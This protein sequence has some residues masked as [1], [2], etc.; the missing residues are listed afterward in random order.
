MIGIFF[1]AKDLFLM[2]MYDQY[3]NFS[4]DSLSVFLWIKEASDEEEVASLAHKSITGV[5]FLRTTLRPQ[6]LVMHY[7]LRCW[8]SLKLRAFPASQFKIEY[9]KI[10]FSQ[11]V[12]AFFL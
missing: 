4:N 9:I 6:M 8:D 10:V 2:K 7:A 3:S 1:K 11:G 5:F 12:L